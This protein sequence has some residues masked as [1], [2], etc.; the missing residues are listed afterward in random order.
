MLLDEAPLVGHSRVSELLL[1]MILLLTFKCWPGYIN[2]AID[3]FFSKETL[4][5]SN[6]KRNDRKSKNGDIHEPLTPSLV[7]YA[8]FTF[9]Q[10]TIK[11]P[12]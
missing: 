3:I 7:S 4:A 11:F 12:K 6:A 5:V 2:A 1:K 9:I 8:T 10:K